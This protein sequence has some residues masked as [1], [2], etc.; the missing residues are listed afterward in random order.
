MPGGN[1]QNG[2]RR[3]EFIAAR[4]GEHTEL[5]NVIETG[6]TAF[7]FSIKEDAARPLNY[8]HEYQ[9]VFIEPN[10]GSHVFGIQ[11]GSYTRHAFS[12]LP[13][14]EGKRQ[15]RRSQTPLEHSP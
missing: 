5:L 15:A 12:G 9:I 7:H 6:V 8:T 13:G 4:D 3:T 10:D 2:F 11:L 1:P 14:T